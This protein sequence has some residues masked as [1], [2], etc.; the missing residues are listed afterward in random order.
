MVHVV[1]IVLWLGVMTG[2]PDVPDFVS[3]QIELV[4]LEEP[5]SGTVVVEAPPA[6]PPQPEEDQPP[7]PEI[8]EPEEPETE[9]PEIVPPPEPIEPTPPA[10]SQPEPEPTETAES[11]DAINVRIE[12]LR[13]DY[14]L[15][16][17]N[18]ITQIQRCFRWTG[19]GAPET[20]VYFVIEA[21]GS[22]SDSRFVR[23]S[24]NPG[25]DYTALGAVECAGEGRFG[26]LPDDLPYDRLPIRFTFRPGTATG[27]FR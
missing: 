8:E 10:P 5:E 13:R 25:F 18:V 17:E 3:Y 2:Q 24:G 16:Y 21:D 20:E 22:V 6:P 15:Y 9:E 1:A 19:T 27:I 23:Q 14:P 26:P 11:A 4:A 12:G 7:P